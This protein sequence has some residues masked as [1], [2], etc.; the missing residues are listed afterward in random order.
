MQASAE[1]ATGT[2]PLASPDLSRL[3]SQFAQLANAAEFLRLS[4]SLINAAG[5]ILFHA[6]KDG[7]DCIDELISRQ[8]LSWSPNL[9]HELAASAHTAM[10][11]GRVHYQRLESA[12]GVWFISCPFFLP[13]QQPACLS[14]IILIDS[15]PLEPFLVI[16]QLLASLLHQRLLLPSALGLRCPA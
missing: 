4:I 7:L 6:G 12:L 3:S 9:R 14:V 1:G 13:G 2:T 5:G 16:A 11:E 10:Q 15:N 8:A